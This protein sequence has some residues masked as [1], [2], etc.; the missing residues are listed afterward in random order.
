[1][2]HAAGAGVAKIQL[3]GVCFVIG[4]KFTD[5]VNWKLCVDSHEQWHFR[6]Q[7]DRREIF[8]RIEEG[9][10]NSSTLV[11]T[12]PDVEKDSVYPSGGAFAT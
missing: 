9:F 1:M 10:L 6:Y 11:A 7:R 8:S 5:I 2:A 4:Q 12:G 3:A